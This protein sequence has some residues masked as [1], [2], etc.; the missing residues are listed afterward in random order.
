[1]GGGVAFLD[2]DG[3]GDL[4][5]L[6]TNVARK[7]GSDGSPHD[8]R[9]RLFRREADGHYLD[10]TKH[11]GLGDPGYG[12]GVAVGDFDN[13]GD[14]DVYCTNLGLD[15]LFRNR[16]D[17]T[18]DD[19]TVDAGIHVDG[20]S[21][22]A[23]FFDFDRDGYLDLFVT[24]YVEYYPRNCFNS[25]GRLDYCGP[26]AFPNI[27]DVLL[28]NNGDGTFTDV[29]ELAGIASVASAGLGVVCEDL[30]GD[31][32]VDIYVANDAYANQLWI[33]QRDGTFRDES[34]S[35]GT[36]FN[37]HGQAEAGM[38]VV[39][40][41]FDGHGHLDLF[42]THLRTESNTLY[43]NLGGDMGFEDVTGSVGLAA[44]SME[45][46]G[47]GTAAFDVELDGDLDLLVVNGR[48]KRNRPTPG[49]TL[50]SPLD[51]FPEANLFYLN[52]GHGSFTLVG[53]KAS[54][55]CSPVEISRGLAIADID[56]D[57]D[58]DLLV[59]NLYGSVRL[60]RN[61]APREGH[62]LMIRAVDPRLKRDAIGAHIT[63]IGGGKQWLR[64]ISRGFSYLS[65]SDPRAHVGLGSVT[66]IDAIHVRWPD[67]L[68]ERFPSGDVDRTV[69]L[70][71]GNGERLP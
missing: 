70:I 26:T 29:S 20:W 58:I 53:E 7:E 42:V 6:L 45:Y 49:A 48:V 5:I 63:V 25:A 15:R 28:H 3:D 39:A 32:W 10:V 19:V 12:M 64:T 41:D 13:D 56:D 33:N 27:H 30:N 66:R 24:R 18:F 9:N 50:P 31:G 38:G 4:D 47:F 17:G 40:A 69:E 67:G 52:D 43:R 21:C 44:S 1:M 59:G 23:V 11:S 62:W 46:T 14:V 34:L 35:M 65:S 71:R 36:A 68:R 8:S 37:M 61:D 55:F 60:Y 16:G 2:V 51:E 22:S 54:E 57:G